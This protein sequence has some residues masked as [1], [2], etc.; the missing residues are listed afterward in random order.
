M[1]SNQT[2]YFIRSK[3]TGIYHLVKNELKGGFHQTLCNLMVPQ[4]DTGDP[5]TGYR[6]CHH[7]QVVRDRDEQ[8]SS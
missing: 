8:R 1:G 7:C 5:P 3:D 4:V 2:K 6:L